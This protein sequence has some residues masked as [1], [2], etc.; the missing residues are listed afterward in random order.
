MKTVRRTKYIFLIC[1]LAT[2]VAAQQAST[3]ENHGIAIQNMDRSVTPGDN[4]FEYCN[5][6]F[7]KRTTIPADRPSVSV[8]SQLSDLAA[9]RTNDVIENV[10][11]SKPKAGTEQRKIA[12]LYHAYMDEAAIESRG[13]APLKPHL[14]A[15]ASIK[16]K[17]QLARALGE[18]L[19][20]D[21]DAL[22]NTNFHTSNLFGVWIAPDFNDPAHHTP[23]MMQGGLALPNR[24]YYLADTPHMREVR[25]KYQAYVSAMMKLAGFS[26]PDMRAQRII[27]LEH[28]I[29]ET[30][31]TLAQNED[32][33]K[34]NNPWTAADF[35]KNAPGLDWTE[36][37]RAAGLEKQQHFIV[38][39]PTAFKGESALVDS[40]P[41]DT[42]KDWLA[43]HLI[44]QY[45]GVLPKSFADERFAFYGG[46]L[47]G[48][49]EQLPRWRR[50]VGTVNADLGDAVGKIYAKRYFS[51]EAKQQADEMV[52][53]IVKAF[54][55]RI[56]ALSWM[57]PQTKAEAKAKLAKLYVGIGYPETWKDYSGLEIKP[58]D[59]FGNAWRSSLFRY[60]QQIG[61]IGKTVD[62]HEWSMTPQ[63]VNA[64]N[65]PLQ[66]ALSFPAAIL[67]PPFF[68]P[69]APSVVNY[70]AIG[71]VI[72]H[73][74]SH[75][76]DTEGSVFD[77]EG[78]MRNWWT[79]ADFAHFKADT[80][81]LAAQYDTYHP[82]PDLAV[83]GEQT[84]AEN[85]ADLAGITASFDAY[86]A[87]MNG[88][89]GP[90]QNGFTADQQFFIAFGQNYANKVR[91]ASLRQQVLTDVHSP[92]QYRALEVRNL[93][94]WYSAFDVKPGQQLYLAPDQR[95]HVW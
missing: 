4:W 42:W 77:A 94:A 10:A 61:R 85:I 12:D 45:A 27:D 25:E 33:H 67:Q 20:A 5:G 84:I 66:D 87:S 43:F 63:T 72:G 74:I 24:Q 60:H 38:W 46:V 16:D 30:H 81:K 48:T 70:G 37:F 36:Y 41:L 79:D 49:P 31:L 90:E 29:A 15:I 9:Q 55:R 52:S 88:K 26:D 6:E 95:V 59:M 51:P 68:D 21:V 91:D 18:T 69:K 64:V 32:V 89:S 23:Y 92:A 50:A 62:R 47:A 22:N 19:R 78:R 44:D 35:A 93:D 14:D 7:L 75:T 17:G 54:E 39:Q 82:F 56:D 3:S 80:A 58:D 83:N 11:K 76:F 40:V 86:H 53:N 34:A 2:V 8:F 13:I 28:S 71:A 65:L 73:E 1:V 57:D